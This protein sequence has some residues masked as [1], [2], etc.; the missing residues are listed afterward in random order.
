[1]KNPAKPEDWREEDW[2]EE[3]LLQWILDEGRREG[4]SRE[5]LESDPRTAARLSELEDFLVDC[6]ASL[7]AQSETSDTEELERE[8]LA[9][10][11]REDLGRGADLRLVGGFVRQRLRRSLLLRVVAASLLL[12]VIA[13]PVVAYYALRLE[14][15]ERGLILR[16]ETGPLGG[17]PYASAEDVEPEPEVVA[18]ELPQDPALLPDAGEL[19]VAL[20]ARRGAATPRGPL[21]ELRLPDRAAWRGELEL[22]LWCEHLLDRAEAGAADAEERL[23][24]PLAYLSDALRGQRGDRRLLASTWL[25]ARRLGVTERLGEE[26]QL[27]GALLESR[28]ELD[29]EAWGEA[30]LRAFGSQ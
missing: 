7:H 29:G 9:R 16:F 25:R 10:T 12:H 17:L 5:E 18:P 28:R 19:L 27:Q 11:T 2:G 15:E 30:Y 24:L 1:M 21:G 26:F 20:R 14:A 8:V 13:L 6:R 22:C 3:D 4:V 23:E